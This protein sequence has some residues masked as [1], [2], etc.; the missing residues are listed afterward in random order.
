MFKILSASFVNNCAT[1]EKL[2]EFVL[3]LTSVETT[4]GMLSQNNF[5]ITLHPGEVHRKAFQDLLKI[6][7]FSFISFGEVNRDYWQHKKDV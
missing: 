7:L 2:V 5:I 6:K 4:S 3:L 1:R